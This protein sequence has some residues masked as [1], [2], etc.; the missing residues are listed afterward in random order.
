MMFV[1]FAMIEIDIKQIAKLPMKWFEVLMHLGG[2]VQISKNIK[3]RSDTFRNSI[4]IGFFTAANH[5][6]EHLNDSTPKSNCDDH[7][8][9]A[10]F[11][12]LGVTA[13]TRN[14]LNYR[15]LI[16]IH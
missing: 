9:S 4:F 15:I 16:K 3:A 5:F 6:S 2:C 12:W 13:I 11:M 8:Q 10:I 14:E 7:I 1:D